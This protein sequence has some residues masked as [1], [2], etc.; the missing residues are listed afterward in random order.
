MLYLALFLIV[1][2]LALENIG[3]LF[4]IA[5]M[6][7]G[8]LVA[9]YTFQNSWSFASRFVNLL[10]APL[11]AYLADIKYIQLDVSHII[12]F[13]VFLFLSIFLSKVYI[14]PL[15]NF[16]KYIVN[17]QQ[18]GRSLLNSIFRIKTLVLFFSLLINYK[19]SNTNK[20]N[21]QSLVLPKLVKYNIKKYVINFSLTYVLFYS[22]WIIVSL[23]ITA[24]P[25][26]PSFLISTSTYFTLSS[27]IYQSVVFDPW[28]SRFTNQKEETLF[29]YILLQDYR[30]YS[31]LF[32]LIFSFSTYL[33]F[34]WLKL[35]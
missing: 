15:I 25:H 10:F 3:F 2:L 33:L 20:Y 35:I 14:N 30:L 16:L 26:R 4:R 28:I 11:F 27:T 1:L 21:T 34:I 13:Y 9:G 18:N 22:C 12:F 31:V 19:I 24:F 29:T 17:E 32:S 5:G 8:N 23:L 6:E 7:L